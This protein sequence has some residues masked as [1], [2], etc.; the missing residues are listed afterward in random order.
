MPQHWES[1]TQLQPGSAKKKKSSSRVQR[2]AHLSIRTRGDRPL[3]ASSGRSGSVLPAASCFQI[4]RVASLDPDREDRCY[5]HRGDGGI[6]RRS[7][8]AQVEEVAMTVA[9]FPASRRRC[10]APAYAPC[11]KNRYDQRYA[12]AFFF[13]NNQTLVP[14]ALT[15]RTDLYPTVDGY[16]H[17]AAVKESHL[18]AVLLLT[19]GELAVSAAEGAET[20]FSAA[21]AG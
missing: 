5:R 2:P 8:K 14:S 15:T 11:R 17:A 21:Y 18:F 4:Q 7:V 20:I 16:S 12:A 19:G 6:H 3:S 9:C 10:S 13:D 1:S